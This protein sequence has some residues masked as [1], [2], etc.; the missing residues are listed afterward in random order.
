VEGGGHPWRRA[1]TSRRFGGGGGGYGS[2]SLGRG[3][4]NDGGSSVDYIG[5]VGIGSCGGIDE[6]GNSGVL[7]DRTIEDG[8]QSRFERT[9]ISLQHK[10]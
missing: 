6:Q 10:K 3:R 8:Q 5:P 4:L 7:L 2:G 9:G 1:P